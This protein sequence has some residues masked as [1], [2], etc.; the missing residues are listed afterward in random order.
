MDISGVSTG[1]VAQAAAQTDPAANAQVTKKALDVETQTNTQLA[2]AIPQVP[3]GNKGNNIDVKV[4]C[5]IILL[6]TLAWIFCS[7]GDLLDNKQ[8]AQDGTC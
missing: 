5:L 8:I 4:Q 3:D 2:D 1:V 6:K 7:V